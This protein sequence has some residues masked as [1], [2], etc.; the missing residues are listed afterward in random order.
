VIGNAGKCWAEFVRKAMKGATIGDEL[1]IG[2]GMIHLIHE[3]VY[4]G[5]RDVRV[6]SAVTH[7]YFA[8]D[9]ARLGWMRSV[10]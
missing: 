6:Q 1:P 4:L 9:G 7:D 5:H 8:F 2:P 3:S 10:K